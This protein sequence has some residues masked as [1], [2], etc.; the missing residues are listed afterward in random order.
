MTRLVS[1]IISFFTII[2]FV[3]CNDRKMANDIVAS[4]FSKAYAEVV[5]S[6]SVNDA[7]SLIDRYLD[8]KTISDAEGKYLKAFAMYNAGINYDSVISVCERALINKYVLSDKNLTYRFSYL[9]TNAA[10]SSGSY[11]DMVRY[12]SMTARVARE[13]GNADVTHQMMAAMGYGIVFMGKYDNGLT[14]IDEALVKLDKTHTWHGRNG[15]IIA[16]KYKISSLDKIGR[17]NE[18]P[19]V[20]EKILQVV[21]E[22]WTERNNIA[23]LPQSFQKDS[24]KYRNELEAYR[25]QALAY[26]AYAYSKA[27]DRRSAMAYL[28]K[29][30]DSPL[31]L[32]TD[33]LRLIVYVY[34]ELG[35]YDEMIRIYDKIDATRGSDTINESYCAELKNRSKAAV[36]KGNEKA[37]RI[38]LQR[39]LNIADSVSLRTNSSQMARNAALYRVNEEQLKASASKAETEVMKIISLFVLILFIILLLF[40]ILQFRQKKLISLKNQ[41]LASNI[42]DLFEY[43]EKYDLLKSAFRQKPEQTDSPQP[44]EAS[45]KDDDLRLFEEIDAMIRNEKL[46]LAT[47]FQRQVLVDKLHADRNRIGRAIREYSGFANLSAYINWFRLEHAIRILQGADSRTTMDMIAKSSGFSTARTF[48]RAFKEKYGMTPSEFRESIKNQ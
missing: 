19:D 4:G 35:R 41:K 43:K 34:A 28:K 17:Q 21:D 5:R 38:Y 12:A 2:F 15:Y 48:Y 31:A 39:A 23:D 29:Y 42:E 18:I 24:V 26:T 8:N 16:L 10:Y 14:L 36:A 44:Q 11:S 7:N 30:M 25:M 3:G 40:T 13:L 32:T 9:L 20:T 45:E 33:G 1:I 22:L 6:A 46:Y 37:A 27:N 47:E